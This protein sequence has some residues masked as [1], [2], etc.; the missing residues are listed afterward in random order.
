V[1]DGGTEQVTLF[2]SGRSSSS[3]T[4]SATESMRSMIEVIFLLERVEGAQGEKKECVTS[5]E[6]DE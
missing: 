3:L 5:S 4:L 2:L 6:P 1:V